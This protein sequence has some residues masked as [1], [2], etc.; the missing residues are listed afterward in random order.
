[1]NKPE[2]G[3][4]FYKVASCSFPVELG[5]V[6]V[7]A[8]KMVNYIERAVNE[9]VQL[10]VFPELSLTGYTCADLFLREDF[11]EEIEYALRTIIAATRGNHLLVCVGMPVEEHGKLF[12]CAVINFCRIF[13]SPF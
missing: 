10:L 7:N 8:K 3:Y 11:Y 2:N 1:M 6:N 5:N 4:G 9:N 13:N 12:N